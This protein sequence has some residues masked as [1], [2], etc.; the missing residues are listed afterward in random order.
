MLPPAQAGEVDMPVLGPELDHYIQGKDQS[1]CTPL[2][3]AIL[4]GEAADLQLA[5]WVG[6]SQLLVAVPW[7]LMPAQT[8][9]AAAGDPTIHESI[10]PMYDTT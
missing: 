4:R 3:V 1:E 10:Q 9:A 5:T 7:P 6:T 2:H 8:C